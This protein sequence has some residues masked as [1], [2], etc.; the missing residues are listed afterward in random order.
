M[1]SAPNQRMRGKGSAKNRLR[2]N[3]SDMPA[4]IQNLSLTDDCPISVSQINSLAEATDCAEQLCSIKFI[5][6]PL[7]IFTTEHHL[8]L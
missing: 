3:K 7:F 6:E 1:A 5:C 2:Q 4:L 8:S